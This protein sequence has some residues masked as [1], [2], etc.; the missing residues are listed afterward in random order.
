VATGASGP[1]GRLLAGPLLTLLVLAGLP[2]ELHGI[3]EA[4]EQS[5]LYAAAPRIVMALG[6][7]YLVIAVLAL[8][9]VDERR[10]ED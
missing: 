5:T 3:P 7:V 1:F 10:R 8:R 6:I 4:A 2:P 9:N